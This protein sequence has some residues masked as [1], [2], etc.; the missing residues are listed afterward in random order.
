MICFLRRLQQCSRRSIR[1]S[2]FNRSSQFLKYRSNAPVQGVDG[3]A[4]LTLV[5]GCDRIDL[6]LFIGFKR[7]P[8]ELVV[9]FVERDGAGGDGIAQVEQIVRSAFKGGFAAERGLEF[10]LPRQPSGVEVRIWARRIAS[11]S[12][13]FPADRNSGDGRKRGSQFLTAAGG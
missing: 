7:Q 3:I 12:R 4:Q 1:R 10:G 8:G 6:R 5:I 13:I 9:Q 11:D 2:R